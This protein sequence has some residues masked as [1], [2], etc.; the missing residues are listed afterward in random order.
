MAIRSFK[1][2]I[3]N[4]GYRISSKDRKIFERGNLQSF[5]G[6]SKSDVIEF[7]VYDVNDNQLPQKDGS[8]VRYI[9]M[10]SENIRDY[11]LIADGTLLQSF[12]FPSE[13]FIDVERLL[14]DAGYNN[15]IFKTQITLINKRVGS[16]IGGEQLWI[17]EI[18][19]SRTEVRLLP[20]K[21][22]ANNKTELYQRYTLMVTGEDFKEDTLPYVTEFINKISPSNIISFLKLAYGEDYYNE[23][24]KEF[25]IQ[26]LETLMTQVYNKFVEAVFYEYTN[27]YSSIRDTR[28][29]Q[30]KPDDMSISLSKEKIK[31]TCIYILTETLDFYL[32][33]RNETTQTGVDFAIDPSLDKISSIVQTRQSDTQY[34]TQKPVITPRV[35]KMGT[36][37]S[38]VGSVSVQQRGVP[39]L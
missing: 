37:V 30:S 20:L 19:P 39:G 28:Y 5:F 13:Y 31:D 1:D 26:D 24:K 8:L 27:R 3:D 35:S 14:R 2:I 10:T 36:S 25:A 9:P 11:F 22:D 16:N 12:N 32:P 29:G 4:K 33:Q 15:G 18:S 21:T 38:G 17:S 7:V 34:N 6:F 23:F